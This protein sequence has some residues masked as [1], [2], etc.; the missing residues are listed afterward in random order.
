[1]RF[2]QKVRGWVTKPL[3]WIIPIF[4]LL[5]IGVNAYN[6]SQREQTRKETVEE[7]NR[8]AQEL[9]VATCGDIP[10][11][12]CNQAELLK[13]VKEIS[14]RQT[15]I[16]CT[17]IRQIADPLDTPSNVR[18]IC[19]VQIEKFSQGADGTQATNSQN[20]T[21]PT[22][23]ADP[24]PKTTTR[25]KPAPEEPEEPEEPEPSLVDQVVDLINPFD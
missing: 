2:W 10:V 20:K 24:K 11:E 1:M 6:A 15:L 4:I 17:M 5:L 9:L 14:E 19:K 13:E 25:P 23:P 8:I 12:R 22:N 18:R 21:Q 3:L 7:T 16:L